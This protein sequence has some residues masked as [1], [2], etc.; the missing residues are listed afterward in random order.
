VTRHLPEDSTHVRTALV[1]R[2]MEGLTA[3]DADAVGACL[4]DDLVFEL[5][6]E[7]SIPPLDKEQFLE[8][9]RTT[10]FTIYRQFTITLSHVYDL[11]DD[12]ALV[13]RYVGDCIGRD[14]DVRYANNYVGIFEFQD[15]L[16]R[17]WLEY[18]DPTIV[19]DAQLEHRRVAQRATA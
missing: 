4:H 5:P 8:L 16:I 3:L 7:R 6:Y 14:D 12:D 2:A 11:R 18:H 10:C 17:S 9:L 15:G 19:A 1:Q 13:A